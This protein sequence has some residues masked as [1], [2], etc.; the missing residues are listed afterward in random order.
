MKTLKKLLLLSLGLLLTT[1][2]AFAQEKEKKE[3]NQAF[4]IHEDQVKPN[5]IGEYEKVSKDFVAM[6]KKHNLQNGDWSTAQMDD[7]RFL[8][9]SPI[10]K[11]A[12]F[13]KNP[14]APLAEKVGNEAFGKIFERFDKCYNAHGDYVVVLNAE[15]SYMPN[16]LSTSTPGEEY[17]KWHFLHVTPDNIQNLKAKLKDLKAYFA[18]K[19]SKMHYRIY[20]N[21]F[22]TMGDY[23]VAVLSAKDAEDYERKAKENQALLG[24]QGK[25][26]FDE[27][28]KYVHKFE[29][30]SGG[31]RADLS[32]AASNN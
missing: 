5:M 26:L 1:N 10:E 4:W 16:G 21:G 17:R 20:H 9:I 30:K 13:D 19:N 22:G 23:Y 29:T 3:K 32:Y 28:F 6:C 14:L 12:D 25:K 15:L 24:E 11:M 7:G 31:M 18:E 27:V 8:T 2:I